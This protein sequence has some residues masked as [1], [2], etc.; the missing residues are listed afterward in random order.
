L[1]LV[2]DDS[3]GKQ[4]ALSTFHVNVTDTIA[5]TIRKSPVTPAILADRHGAADSGALKQGNADESP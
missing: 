1:S 3:S 2:S 4:N 5:I